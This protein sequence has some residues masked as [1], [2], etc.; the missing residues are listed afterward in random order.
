VTGSGVTGYAVYYGTS[1]RVYSG[2]MDA[3][4][5]TQGTMSGLVPG[6]KYFFA[7]T[8]YNSSGVE[9]DYSAEV[10]SIASTAPPTVTLTS[11]IAGNTLISPATVNFAATV[12]PNGHTIKK[13]R[14]YNAVTLVGES[15]SPPYTFAWTNVSPGTYTVTAQ[16]V[17]DGGAVQNSTA[18]IFVEAPRPTLAVA[19]APSNAVLTAPFALSGGMI[20]QPVQTTTVSTAGRA[21]F[22]FTNRVAGNYVVSAQVLAPGSNANSF[23]VNFDAMPTDPLMVWNVPVNPAP[24]NQT[25]T[26]S[27]VSDNVPKAFFLSAGTH[28]L[29]VCGREAGAQLGAITIAPAPFSLKSLS[30]RQVVLSAVAQP[31][32]SYQILATQD[33]KKWTL[34]AT[35]KSDATGS[36][37]FT[38]TAAP[39]FPYRFYQLKG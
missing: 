13:V 4:T 2:R 14:F 29:I 9:S 5:A 36:I 8:A 28:Q 3:S 16:A 39:S 37:S 1:S 38:D 26:W 31:N 21:V 15:F 7:V 30:N 10:S 24:T 17:Y 18:Q 23:Y 33:F 25:V 22:A 20:S 12:T 32:S 34:I 11:P 19:V 35:I 27:G 6:T